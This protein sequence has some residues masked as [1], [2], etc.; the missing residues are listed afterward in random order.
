[1]A[2][3]DSRTSGARA[4]GRIGPAMRAAS[5]ASVLAFILGLVWLPR[6]ASQ[7]VPGQY[8]RV[9]AGEVV[10]RTLVADDT[11]TF[12]YDGR[13]E[14]HSVDAAGRY[15]LVEVRCISCSAHLCASCSVPSHVLV[16]ESC[17]TRF[18]TTPVRS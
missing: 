10:E 3:R 8:D 12:E 5:G 13:S 1:M 18:E 4:L 15:M 11:V 6:S 2:A 17:G 9:V 14:I 16:S 7:P